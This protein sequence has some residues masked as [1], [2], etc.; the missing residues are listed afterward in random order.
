MS[1]SSRRGEI[2][3]V[4]LSVE[5]PSQIG[6]QPPVGCAGGTKRNDVRMLAVP[7][8]LPSLLA[9]GLTTRF[10]ASRLSPEIEADNNHDDSKVVRDPPKSSQEQVCS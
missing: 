1:S 6:V 3:R 4:N 9:S 8:A 7:D 10:E 5:T 2:T